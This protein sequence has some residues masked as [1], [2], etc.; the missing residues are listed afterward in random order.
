MES[1]I[2]NP[3]TLSDTLDLECAIEGNY[4]HQDI[5]CD[6][7]EKPI[8]GV[9]FRCSKCEDYDLCSDCHSTG[10]AS[11]HDPSHPFYWIQYRRYSLPP[12]N[13][14]D[15]ALLQRFAQGNT[16][17]SFYLHYPWFFTPETFERLILGTE[18]ETQSRALLVQLQ[19]HLV[20]IE[21]HVAL[22]ALVRTLSR[23]DWKWQAVQ[24]Y[25]QTLLQL[26][27]VRSE[28]SG[29]FYSLFSAVRDRDTI[30]QVQHNGSTATSQALRM[31]L[32]NTHLDSVAAGKC[33]AAMNS[34]LTATFSSYRTA[35]VTTQSS[36]ISDSAKYIEMLSKEFDVRV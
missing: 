31:Q 23:E 3:T 10:A 1:A 5:Q 9:R 2:T 36:K 30:E 34:F 33:K 8:V 27:L 19:E 4:T 14:E 29:L 20:E 6:A 32:L 26:Q 35:E 22:D 28:Y 17:Q 21:L 15:N 16:C 12:A 11:Q 25:V 24:D 7:C 13:G 18:D